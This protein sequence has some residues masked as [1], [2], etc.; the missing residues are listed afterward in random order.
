MIIATYD[1]VAADPAGVGHDRTHLPLN[2]RAARAERQLLAA[3]PLKLTDAKLNA[4]HSQ[5]VLW[6]LTPCWQQDAKKYNRAK[7]LL[8]MQIEIREA[9][10]VP[11]PRSY[12]IATHRGLWL[13]GA[14][15]LSWSAKCQEMPGRCPD[16]AH[17]QGLTGDTASVG[18]DGA[19]KLSD[20][21]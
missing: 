19:A 4:S 3:W 21:P 7:N 20:S 11:L 8:A 18:G 17:A 15:P 5:A 1:I 2:C 14:T 16:W 9:R 12:C 10:Q 6:G 13:P